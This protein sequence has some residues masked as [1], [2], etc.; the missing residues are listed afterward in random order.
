VWTWVVIVLGYAVSVCFF[1]IVGGV[2]SACDAIQSW[3]RRSSER[4]L[5]RSGLSAGEF[6]RSRLGRR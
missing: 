3:G 4:T 1:H 6:A 2:A 5:E